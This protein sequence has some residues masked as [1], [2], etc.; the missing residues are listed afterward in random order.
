MRKL[1]LLLVLLIG[2]ALIASS[3]FA[4]KAKYGILSPRRSGEVKY[5]NNLKDARSYIEAEFNSSAMAT[6]GIVDTIGPYPGTYNVNFGAF[7]DD[8]FF[9]WFDPGADCIIKEVWIQFLYKGSHG[10]GA[11][12]LYKTDFPENVPDDSFDADG[13]VGYYGT[14]DT[15]IGP[16]SAA[17]A[18]RGSSWGYDP[19]KELIW[20]T[21]DG[22]PITI[23]EDNVWLGTQMIF[24]GVEPEIVSGEKF[25]IVYTIKGQDW[26]DDGRQAILSTGDY[27]PPHPGVKFYAVS[28]QNEGG[29]GGSGEYGWII[30]VYTWGMRVVVEFTSNTAPVIIP[31]GPYGTVLNADAKTLECYISDIDAADPNNAGVASAKLYYKINDGA[32]QVMDMDLISGTDTDGTWGGTLSAGYMN[33]G[34]VLTYWFEATDKGGMTSTAT[35]GSFGYFAKTTEILFYYNDVSFSL[36][37]AM[38]TYWRQPEHLFDA[39]GGDRD[40]A[41]TATLLDQY[42]YIVRVDG[43]YPVNLD[44]DVFSTWLASGTA[45][46]P[47]YLFWSSVEFLGAETN[48]TDSTYATDD[49]HNMYL[50][51]GS[52]IHDLQYQALGSYPTT[53]WAVN[54]VMDDPISGPI[55]KLAADSSWQLVHH[56]TYELGSSYEFSDGFVLGTDAVACFTDS[57]EGRPQGIHKEGATTKTVFLGL[58]QLSLDFN[59]PYGTPGYTWCEYGYPYEDYAQGLSVLDASLKWFGA[60]TAVDDIKSGIVIDYSLNQNYPNPFN[61]IT[62]ITYS[63]AKPGHVKLS[64]YNVLGQKVAE[65]VNEHKAAAKYHVTWDAKDLSSGVYFYRLEVGDYTRTMKMMLLR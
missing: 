23:P 5:I 38:A 65:L 26:S 53:P 31:G 57:M 7:S 24:L 6:T 43:D 56:I 21:E 58:D 39:W 41:T 18:W 36:E 11:L 34:D 14:V 42:D 10:L 62:K 12:Q 2:C 3:V 48:W 20:G 49:W 52:V 55:A 40:G 60:P 19:L 27:G 32:D 45:Q 15:Q 37:D 25:A 29:G 46:N 47:K 44:S 9:E 28:S 30:R 64:V 16:T 8:L 51:I 59:P 13:W 35:G 50:G 17:G 22:F 4:Q 33:P 63:V 1:S 61:P 54:A